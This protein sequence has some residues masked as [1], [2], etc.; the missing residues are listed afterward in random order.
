[1]KNIL[2]LNKTKTTIMINR[3]ITGILLVSSLSIFYSCK[4]Q[5]PKLPNIVLIF[6][7]DMG[8]AD[9]SCF[10]ASDYQTPN[11]DRLATEGARFTN[12]YASQAVCSASRSSLLTGCYAE[13]VGIQGALNSYSNIGIN[14]DETLIPEMLKEKGYATVIFGKWHLGH[15]KQFLPLQHGFDE[16][17]GLPYSNDMWPVGYDGVPLN[18]TG[19]R[20]SNYPPL[21]LFDGNEVIDTIAN[22]NDQGQL[23]S[24]Y[25]N[26]AVQF[27]INHKDQPFF[28]YMPHSMVHVPIAVSD[29][30]KGKSKKGL[31]ADVMLELDWSVGEITKALIENGLDENTLIIFTADNGP[32]LNYGNHAGSALPLREGKGCMWEGG[33][34]VSTMMRW[35]EVI[36]A[37]LVS[38][39]IASTIDV[40]PTL[41]EITGAPLPAKKIDGV[42]ILTLM[43]GK[44][45]ANPRNQFYYYYGGELIAVRKGNW[46]LVF[47]HHYRSYKGVEPGHDGFPGPYAKGIVKEMELYNLKDDISETTNLAGQYPDIVKELSI[48][49][50]SARAELGDRIQNIKGRNVREPGRRTV[51]KKTVEH[52]AI[53]KNISIINDYSYQYDGSGDKTLVNGIYGSLDYTDNEWLG[54]E[55]TDLEA[56]IDL[57]KAIPVKKVECGFLITQKSWIFGPEKVDISISEDG[58]NYTLVKSFEEDAQAQDNAQEVKK[59]KAQINNQK[60]RFI[61]I[62]AKNVGVCPVWHDGAGSKCWLFVDEIVIH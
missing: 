25:T 54:F 52:L 32:W 8:Y 53:N 39:K 49:G 47:P 10:G 23:T 19:K 20:K 21:T 30:F 38:D 27:I 5:E 36:P 4:P 3:V 18:G 60:V 57:E 2:L 15:H 37:G 17:V 44:S 26:K 56:T 28:L 29:K 55:G 41:S 61:K 50:D 59:Y 48:I 16:Y 58:K 31:F 51:Q 62:Q 45:E 46:K 33:P 13:R 1:M 24:I 22:L 11:I 40:L 34:R 14:P 9:V 6:I 35:P 43:K 12:F 42:S 7:D